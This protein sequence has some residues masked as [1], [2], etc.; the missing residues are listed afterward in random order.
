MRDQFAN[1]FAEEAKL[2]P[3]LMMVVADISPA[4]AM[5]KFKEESPERFI[6]VGVAEQIMVGIAAGL[7]LKGMRPFVY[8]IATFT[9]YRPFEFIRNDLAYQNL[10]V[11]AVGM[12][13]GIVYSTLGSTHHAMEDIA[14]AA[15][16]IAHD[17]R[18]W[19][20]NVADFKDIPNLNLV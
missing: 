3:R 14:I 13:A 4:G 16:A 8:T 6:N 5:T 10:P 17:A 11:T 18:V 9:L 7:A 15:S 1:C 12:G 2:D 19:T 20:L